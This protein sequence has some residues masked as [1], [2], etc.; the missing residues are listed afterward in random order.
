MKKFLKK[1]LLFLLPILLVLPPLEIYLRRIPNAY[2]LKY[3]YMAAHAGE[4]ETLILGSSHTYRGIDPSLL[5]ARAFNLAYH[6]QD[7]LRDRYLFDLFVPR[8]DSLETVITSYSY[9]S[10][11]EKLEDTPYGSTLLKYYGMYMAYPPTRV[12]LELSISGWP[13][14]IYYRMF[15]RGILECDSL[16]FGRERLYVERKPITEASAKRVAAGHL[17]ADT[18]N[19][20]ANKEC[21]RHMASECSRRGVRLILLAV[22]VSPQYYAA[23][24]SAQLADMRSFANALEAEFD[25][26]LFLDFMTDDRF[27][28]DDFFDADHLAP[29]GAGKMTGVIKG[30]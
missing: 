30:L 14:K 17:M 11:S 10:L 23:L 16:G 12:S 6:S 27:T 5:S 3:D 8:M 22:P 25:N 29:S 9:F 21:Y 1:T 7:V 2:K 20:A 13:K 28:E 26:V 4:V 19:Y 18:L 15:G 24:D